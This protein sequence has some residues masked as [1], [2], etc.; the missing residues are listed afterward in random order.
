MMYVSLI[1]P[2]RA[3][4]TGRLLRLSLHTCAGLVP[5][6]ST[7]FN[8]IGDHMNAIYYLGLNGPN[9][10]HPCRLDCRGRDQLHIF[11][12]AY[13]YAAPLSDDDRAQ[14]NTRR[15]GSDYYNAVHSAGSLGARLKALK[16]HHVYVGQSIL[17]LVL[18]IAPPATVPADF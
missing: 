8:M 5:V 13:Q 6:H 7:L 12:P 15:S 18:G 10:L 11:D 1:H 2:L 9:K 16:L 3:L 4:E 14:I 17:T